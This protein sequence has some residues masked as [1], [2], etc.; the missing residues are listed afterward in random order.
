MKTAGTF[1]PNPAQPLPVRGVDGDCAARRAAWLAWRDG[2]SGTA[3]ASQLL[4]KAEALE[5]ALS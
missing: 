1:N 4:A 5:K 2:P 3:E